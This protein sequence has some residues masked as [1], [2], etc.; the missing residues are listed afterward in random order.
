[1]TTTRPL[2]PA[3]Y[4]NNVLYL[5][6]AE[7]LRDKFPRHVESLCRSSFSNGDNA[8]K[9]HGR[10]F[11]TLRT[12][13][14]PRLMFIKRIFNGSDYWIILD[15]EPEHDTDRHRFCDK[16]LLENAL[17]KDS[18][19]LLKQVEELELKE[20]KRQEDLAALAE[21]PKPVS[22]RPLS[23]HTTEEKK[24]APEQEIKE[25][26]E[27]EKRAIAE[28]YIYFN[29]QL[30]ALNKL[31]DEAIHAAQPVIICG[32]PGTGKSCVAMEKLVGAL[33]TVTAEESKEPER[34]LYTASSKNLCDNMKNMRQN[35]PDNNPEEADQ[36]EFDSYFDLLQK[37]APEIQGRKQAGKDYFTKWLNKHSSLK[38]NPELK[39]LLKE[40]L[41]QG[42]ELN[43]ALYQ[44]CRRI[45]ALGRKECEDI[46]DR[47]SLFAA[48]NLTPKNQV[49][50]RRDL[51]SLLTEYRN[52]LL[53]KTNYIDPA[54]YELDPEVKEL[55][56]Q[57]VVDEAQDLSPL[58]LTICA[59]L[60]KTQTIARY[61]PT[62]AQGEK[63]AV[64]KKNIT[65]LYDGHQN[66]SDS[67]SKLPVL[68]KIFGD[69]ITEKKLTES[70]R[71]SKNVIKTANC[72][73][74][75]G[76]E[77]T[78]GQ[79]KDTEH[80]MKPA[81][82]AAL[83]HTTWIDTPSEEQKTEI[84]TLIQSHNCAIIIPPD[85]R[86]K[87]EAEF[88]WKEIENGKEVTK[89]AQIL[90]AEQA[91]GLEFETVILWRMLEDDR[92]KEINKLLVD[93]NPEKVKQTG[94][95]KNKLGQTKK[96]CPA[97][98]PDIGILFAATTRARTSLIFLNHSPNNVKRNERRHL[99][100]ALQKTM[101]NI[102]QSAALLSD[103]LGKST[104]EDWKK[105]VEDYLSINDAVNAK[106]FY[107]ANVEN[108]MEKF[109]LFAK[110][111]NEKN[112]PKENET[113]ASAETAYVFNP[114]FLEDMLKQSKTL[115]RL[116]LRKYLDKDPV[117]FLFQTPVNGL[118]FIS[119]IYN[120][121]DQEKIDSLTELLKIKKYAKKFKAANLVSRTIKTADGETSIL[122][123]IFNMPDGEK[124]SR[125]LINADPDFR[126]KIVEL[127]NSSGTTP[128][129]LELKMILYSPDHVFKYELS[130]IVNNDQIDC[131][132]DTLIDGKSFFSHVAEN[133]SKFEIFLTIIMP[134]TNTKKGCETLLK[135]I[136]LNTDIAKRITVNHLL[137]E[138][139]VGPS[140]EVKTTSLHERLTGS[141]EG[142]LVLAE[143]SKHNPNVELDMP[144]DVIQEHVREGKGSTAEV[145]GK[146][147][148]ERTA[149]KALESA[150][151]MTDSSFKKALITLFDTNLIVHLFETRVKGKSF[152]LH[153]E[154]DGNKFKILNDL[155][156]EKIYA[157]KITAVLLKT[158]SIHGETRSIPLLDCLLGRA[159]GRTLF[160]TSVTTCPEIARGFTTD[161]LVGKS[162]LLDSLCRNPETLEA[163][164][165]LS[166]NNQDL[167]KN[168]KMQD[169]FSP[170]K[171]ELPVFINTS[172]AYWLSDWHEEKNPHG[173]I[174]FQRLLDRNSDRI[175]EITADDL[176]RARPAKAGKEA[177]K[178]I[179]YNLAKNYPVLLLKIVS[180]N[181][182]VIKG[183][184]L[185]DLTLPVAEDKTALEHL[186]SSTFGREILKIFITHSADSEI[187]LI[188]ATA[189][190]NT[191]NQQDVS[192]TNTPQT[193]FNSTTTQSGIEP[194]MLKPPVS[195][196]AARSFERK[197]P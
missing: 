10:P 16:T 37:L 166:G 147:F 60:T 179:F 94:R 165:I 131:L 48:E 144:F 183:F 156:K 157:E 50:L 33:E 39:K 193:L 54:F 138:V 76:T 142:L 128:D 117:T 196:K 190:Q 105:R 194:P 7:H 112:N 2:P 132:F 75:M 44:E 65:Y 141:P 91:K 164:E 88:F 173:P 139:Q 12:G 86:E 51:H 28:E 192:V 189:K 52:Y 53:E 77:I 6:S 11:K 62:T 161:D 106:K 140:H 35:A 26:T 41:T 22:L 134:L 27:N 61:L 188:D 181:P 187:K 171:K 20:K 80:E 56:Y 152:Y 59:R 121:K 133:P 153:I 168:L 45:S 195:H 97:Y 110:S 57:V 1:M 103:D 36:I 43:D 148:E 81:S 74:A 125:F 167:G 15:H 66:L 85:L 71:C 130:E 109:D 185:S 150:L 31:Q 82:E 151:A 111:F 123:Y 5:S 129:P 13:I 159:R 136:Q 107:L 8:E 197:G 149:V 101:S 78:G 176:K 126:K 102:K 93:F 174:I 163:F 87:A 145:I 99:R 169:L 158:L 90:T 178:S 96:L 84:K 29:N 184:T 25:K 135:I 55:F 182:D 191:Q 143:I 160:C 115:F 21:S 30:I 4:R 162:Q 17:Q 83:G 32:L 46:K 23:I 98:G 24:P 114:K 18:D 79:D 116:N 100:E 89:T 9:M 58:Q 146:E 64:T 155:L 34:I 170:A 14:R 69:E 38:T 120:T 73:L 47:G 19:H 154:A 122:T 104:I 113:S 67:Q 40:I 172:P 119:A 70:L 3:D 95:G 72:I 108:N 42:A 124:F 49:A 177:N 175:K 137:Q 127:N 180:N 118:P 186:Q 68:K 63:P 92:Y